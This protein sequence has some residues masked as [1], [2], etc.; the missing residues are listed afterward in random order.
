MAESAAA[1][2]SAS[3][4]ANEASAKGGGQRLGASKVIAA[5]DKLNQ[6][7]RQ[8]NDSCQRDRAGGGDDG[9]RL[10]GMR[11]PAAVRSPARGLHTRRA[12]ARIHHDG[13]AAAQQFPAAGPFGQQDP[14]LHTLPLR[15]K[16]YNIIS[17][18]YD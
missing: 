14:A 9:R 16:K 15:R 6:W 13:A 18:Q 8:Y 5:F 3:A 7:D 1:G 10:P 11:D 17:G 2:V 12:I 4:A